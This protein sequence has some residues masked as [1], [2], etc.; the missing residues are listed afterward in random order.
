V[1]AAPVDFMSIYPTLC[2]LAG[3]PRPAHVEGANLRPL[4]EDPLR[5]WNLP[6]LTTYH[7]NN[8]SLRTAEWRY[9]RYADGAEELYHHPSDPYEWTNVAADPRHATTKRALAAYFPTTNAPPVPSSGEDDEGGGKKKSDRK[10][11]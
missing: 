7:Q 6:A 8:H 1:C 2:D 4:L 9:T 5:P 11:H 3:V 10:K